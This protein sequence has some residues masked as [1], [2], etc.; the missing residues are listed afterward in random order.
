MPPKTDVYIFHVFF[1]TL[2][3]CPIYQYQILNTVLLLHLKLSNMKN[4][5]INKLKKIIIN[6]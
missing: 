1:K 2:H 6:K 4:N 3:N 5:Y